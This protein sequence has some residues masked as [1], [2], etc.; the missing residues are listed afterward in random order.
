MF[1]Y[2]LLLFQLFL[3]GHF[4][5]SLNGHPSNRNMGQLFYARKDLIG[6]KQG[7]EKVPLPEWE[8]H[9]GKLVFQ[10]DL[11]RFFRNSAHYRTDEYLRSGATMWKEGFC[12]LLILAIQS[13]MC[14]FLVKTLVA[15]GSA[16]FAPVCQVY[17]DLKMYCEV[18]TLFSICALMVCW[19]SCVRGVTAKRSLW[20]F[21]IFMAALDLTWNVWG[22]TKAVQGIKGQC[23]LSAPLVT[24]T[25]NVCIFIS[26]W[27]TFL[28][29]AAVIRYCLTAQTTREN[30][31]AI[32][33]KKFED[34][35]KEIL[36]EF[37]IDTLSTDE[38]IEKKARKQLSSG[39]AGASNTLSSMVETA[40]PPT[41]SNTV[42][43]ET[44]IDS[45]E[46]KKKD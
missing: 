28:I 5:M 38:A 8:W 14:I 11:T 43:G 21:F 6:T 46:I 42:K 20:A 7:N 22:A 16:E 30:A 3:G 1:G 33:T 15:K 12:S 13:S 32:V 2:L 24:Q 31:K 4:H 39:S 17:E 26:M 35:R 19:V 36:G 37:A 29:L 40:M 41:D 27:F 45:L 44:V 34:R 23:A 25:A 18:E 10:G 9:F